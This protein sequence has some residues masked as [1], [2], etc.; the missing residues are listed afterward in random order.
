MHIKDLYDLRRHVAVVTGGASGLGLQMATGLAEAGASLVIASRRLET[1][2]QVSNRLIEEH[3]VD[4]I[5]VQL[6]VTKEEDVIH[7]AEV[8]TAHYGKVDILINNV[9]GSTI[10]ATISTT[11]SD[12]NHIMDLNLTSVFL[13]CREV[14]RHMIQR[15]YGKIINIA[16][17]YGIMGAD[18]RNYVPPDN[19]N[20]E[21]LS[22]CATKGG[23]INLTRDLAVNWA[24]YNINV[25]AISP[26]G[27]D[28]EQRGRG[29]EVQD[30]DMSFA[31]AKIRSATP[32]G[33]FG[34]EDDLK[35]AAVFLASRASAYVTGHNLVVDGGWSCW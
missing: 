16:S 31:K 5:A 6:D 19:T 10:G 14:G 18:W 12:W 9:G 27:F 33:R 32:T 17:V 28:T 7:L 30:M 3:G 34:G 13:C 15:R 24:K 11:L 4:A 2:T 23:I 8:A 29:G 1:C 20:Y 25:N 26:G 35:G 21:L 22:C